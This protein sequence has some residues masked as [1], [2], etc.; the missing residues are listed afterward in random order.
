MRNVADYEC[1]EFE[2]RYEIY[3]GE[4]PSS[5][6]QNSRINLAREEWGSILEDYQLHDDLTSSIHRHLPA[7]ISWTNEP[8]NL[9]V[10]R[11]RIS[12]QQ[13]FYFAL[14]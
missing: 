4:H 13:V 6:I 14:Y 9:T 5:D 8:S 12:E 7:G 2:L 3:Q 1:S 10:L 11:S